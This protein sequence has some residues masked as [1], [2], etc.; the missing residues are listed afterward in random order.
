MALIRTIAR[1]QL[2]T[3]DRIVSTNVT[4]ATLDLVKMEEPALITITTTRAI[5][6]TDSL[7][8]TALSTSIGVHRIHA[9]MGLL[10][11]NAKTPTNA[12]A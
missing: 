7:A 8:K 10:V 12:N 5:V 2:A 6:L 1:A 9:R 11:H 4:R 3:R